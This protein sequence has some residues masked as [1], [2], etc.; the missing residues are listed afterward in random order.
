MNR[1]SVEFIMDYLNSRNPREK[2]MIILFAVV[3]FLTLDYF[4]LIQP[5]AGTF[6]HTLPELAASKQE[7]RA[8]KDDRKN[9]QAIRKNWQE[10]KTAFADKEKMFI[11][12]NET[13]AL[14]ENLSRLAQ[15]AGLKI[16]SLRPLSSPEADSGNYQRIPIRISATAGTHE[17]GKFLAQL[18][19]GTIFI[20]I[21][22]L[23]ITAN[24]SDIR[25]HSI[26]LALEAFRKGV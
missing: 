20:R 8:L 10:A 17:L 21:T 1:I 12:A 18:E 6:V 13:P 22:D 2:V 26:E 19:S 3:A 24:P 16:V 7:L 14:L 25:R 23:K 11:A 4:V 5:V 9:K 15:S